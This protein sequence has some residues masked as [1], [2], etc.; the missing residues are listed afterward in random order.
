MGNNVLGLFSTSHL[1]INMLSAISSATV[2][3]LSR[4]A[5]L[6][7]RFSVGVI[8]RTIAVHHTHERSCDSCPKHL[9]RHRRILA[10][11]WKRS[12]GW[13]RPQHHC[14]PANQRAAQ[15]RAALRSLSTAPRQQSPETSTNASDHRV[16]SLG[17]GMPP[18]RQV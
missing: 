15:G 10:V 12:A 13:P 14:G 7:Y 2:V 4:P 11:C 8:E 3:L 17:R 9:R 5:L 6:Q 18:G 16:L 1:E